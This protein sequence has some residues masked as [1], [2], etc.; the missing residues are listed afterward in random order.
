[1]REWNPE[2]IERYSG[3]PMGGSYYK[4][5]KGYTGREVSFKESVIATRKA[6]WEKRKAE[7][8]DHFYDSGYSPN[9]RNGWK[10]ESE[11]WTFYK[12]A[13]TKGSVCI[14]WYGSSNGYYSESVSFIKAKP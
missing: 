8:G 10:E 12:L 2:I 6:N 9:P 7:Q 4:E 3:D 13:T 14:R 1:M 11:T 5:P